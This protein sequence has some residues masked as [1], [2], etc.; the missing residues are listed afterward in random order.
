MMR[1]DRPPEAGRRRATAVREQR[2]ELAAEGMEGITTAL[3]GQKTF[4]RG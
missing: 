4:P 1:S 2:V 3:G